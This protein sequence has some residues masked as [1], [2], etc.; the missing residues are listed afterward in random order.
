VRPAVRSA[1]ADAAGNL[2]VSLSVPYTYV[3]DP[4]GQRRRTVQF[5]GVRPI[6][7]IAMNFDR[8]GNLLATPGCYVFNAN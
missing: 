8:S 3:Y 4:T 6:L 5:V 1:A 7:P 2:W